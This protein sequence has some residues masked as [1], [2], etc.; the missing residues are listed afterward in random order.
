MKSTQVKM[1]VANGDSVSVPLADIVVKVEG[2][3]Y[4]LE[5][6]VLDTLPVDVLLGRDVSLG[7]HLWNHMSK[8][9]RFYIAEQVLQSS[10]M[11]E[12]HAVTTRAQAKKQKM[13][14][15]VDN[16]SEAQQEPVEKT[17]SERLPIEHTPS[18]LY[19]IFPFDEELFYHSTDRKKGGE[20]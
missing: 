17:S 19:E 20:E 12:A 1:C 6:A 13:L 5:V 10:R 9:E 7:Q 11:E 8:K 4:H 2:E 15:V 3:V 14:D 16:L 18:V